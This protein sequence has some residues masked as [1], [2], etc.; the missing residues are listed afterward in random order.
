MTDTRQE[1]LLRALDGGA[2]PMP[3]CQIIAWEDRGYVVD[4]ATGEVS[5]A[6]AWRI[7]PTPSGRAVGYL[8]REE[9]QN[10]NLRHAE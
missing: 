8:L 4:L 6:A 10:G 7:T 1:E 2:L 5:P 9:G 3:V